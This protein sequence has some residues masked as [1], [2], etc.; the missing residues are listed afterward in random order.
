MITK[1]KILSYTVKTIFGTFEITAEKR[2]NNSRV[3]I[4]INNAVIK[5]EFSFSKSEIEQYAKDFLE[6]LNT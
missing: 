3:V 5:K 4:N 6:W 2:E 1:G